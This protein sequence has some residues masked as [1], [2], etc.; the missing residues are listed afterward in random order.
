MIQTDLGSMEIEVDTIKTPEA[1]HSFLSYVDQA[2]YQGGRFHRT[3]RA[4]RQSRG[5]SQI[6]GIEGGLNPSRSTELPPIALNGRKDTGLSLGDNVPSAGGGRPDAATADFFIRVGDQPEVGRLDPDGRGF[7][8][9]GRVVRG[10]EVVRL[11]QTARAEQQRLIPPI[12]ITNIT[13]VK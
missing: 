5:K 12:A 11:I 8:P 1:A 3:V 6:E 10:R 2:A 7:T 9:F 13:R 4:E